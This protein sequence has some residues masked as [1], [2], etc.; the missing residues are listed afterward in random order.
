[1]NDPES[2]IL[3]PAGTPLGHLIPLSE[4]KYQMVQR[5]VN[6]RDYDWVE[7]VRSVHNSTFWWHTTR[8]KVVD[9]YKK[10]WI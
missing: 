1:M 4:K 5:T 7:R 2:E 8:S 3:I 9:M 10:Y 6:Q